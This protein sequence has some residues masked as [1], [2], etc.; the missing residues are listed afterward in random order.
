MKKI[1][2]VILSVFML[3]GLVSC[4][5]EEKPSSSETPTSSAASSEKVSS[6]TNVLASAN[7]KAKEVIDEQTDDSMTDIEKAV[8]LMNEYVEKLTEARTLSGEIASITC[9]LDLQFRV[10]DSQEDL[11]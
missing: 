1:F 8:D 2:A 7:E 10:D 4:A 3:L 9:N 11:R 6:E 5:G